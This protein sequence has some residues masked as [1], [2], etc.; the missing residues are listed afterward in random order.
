MTR[1]LQRQTRYHNVESVFLYDICSC[2]FFRSHFVLE[3]D[4]ITSTYFYEPKVQQTGQINGNH[5]EVG[6]FSEQSNLSTSSSFSCRCEEFFILAIF[7]SPSYIMII[8]I[9]PYGVND[10]I[11]YYFNQSAIFVLLSSP[12]LIYLL[13]LRQR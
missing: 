7:Q 3:L 5:D 2:S 11:V 8:L 9:D 10:V 12:N 13:M 6:S 1:L 4:F